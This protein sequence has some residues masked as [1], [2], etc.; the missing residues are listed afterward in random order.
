MSKWIVAICLV[1]MLLMV[2]G[3]TEAQSRATEEGGASLL[4]GLATGDSLENSL[5]KGGIHGVKGWM[6]GSRE[7]KRNVRTQTE[8]DALRSQQ[9]QQNKVVIWITNSNGSE[10][11]V[12]L[13]KDGYGGY[14][15]P[16]GE[17]YRNMPT[18]EQLRQVYGF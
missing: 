9:N 8:I 4:S 13:R 15:G 2:G 7:D 18:K 16:R 1:C 12:V 5:I 10:T 6:Q 11:K 3:C 14:I 17:R